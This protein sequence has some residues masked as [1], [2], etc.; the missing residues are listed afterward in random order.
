MEGSDLSFEFAY[1]PGR[2]VFGR[3]CV[4]RL[5]E[6][7]AEEGV[8]RGLVVC[9]RNVGAN[10]RTLGPVLDGIGDRLAGVFDRTTPEKRLQTVYQGI[11]R[12]QE[13]DV[14]GLI[15]LGG[16]SS[17]NVAR[18]MAFLSATDRAQ[19]NVEEELKQ[20]GRATPPEHSPVPLFVVPTTLAGAA[21]SDGGSVTLSSAPATPPETSGPRRVGV[22]ADERL[23]PNGL[24]FDPSLVETAPTDVLAS[25]A[26][27][28]FDK[29]IETL[30]SREQTPITDATSLRGLELL[31]DSLPNLRNVETGSNTYDTV[32]A[33]VVLT[34]Y[35]CRINLLHAVCH[36]LSY[37]YP[38]SQGVTHGVMAPHVLRFVFDR[39]SGRRRLLA[40]GLG[41]S[42]EGR[43]TEELADV[44]VSRVE[45]VRDRL[46]LPT[47]LRAVDGP[48]K[49][50]L[51][52]VAETIVVHENFERN[53]PTISP[54]HAD[55]ESILMA[56]W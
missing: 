21:I 45:C 5:N 10:E 31:S 35:A 42:T 43:S 30:Y 7:L 29:G 33:G 52:Q 23:M 48:D 8:S 55:V 14:D 34:E 51:E 50:E 20:T 9:G 4:N 44:V 26:M 28:G 24:V 12:M 15:G 3:G 37:Y 38:L 46:G 36:G 54:T 2:I 25:S 17:L 56:A 32:L 13:D 39:A 22:V 1:Q 6:M 49:N 27:N 40:R 19:D 16:G 11:D 18:A 53:P 41:I 47:T